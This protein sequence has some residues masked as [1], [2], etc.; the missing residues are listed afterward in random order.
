[1]NPGIGSKNIIGNIF[2]ARSRGGVRVYFRNIEHGAEIVGYSNKTNQQ[3]VI[4]KI[5]KIYNNG[6]L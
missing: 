3:Q 5:L 6:K 1:M 2:E 4:N